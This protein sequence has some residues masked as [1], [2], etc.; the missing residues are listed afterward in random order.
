MSVIVGE[1]VIRSGV[2]G[3]MEKVSF[4]LYVRSFIF[5]VKG[6]LEEVDMGVVGLVWGYRVEVVF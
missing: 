1:E 5:L 3:G 6:Y 4:F 2:G